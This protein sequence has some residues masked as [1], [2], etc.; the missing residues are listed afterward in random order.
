MQEF[1]LRVMKSVLYERCQCF[2]STRIHLTCAPWS[3]GAFYAHYLCSSAFI[4]LFGYPL[5]LRMLWLNIFPLFVMILLLQPQR[6]DHPNNLPRCFR[7]CLFPGSVCC[8][9]FAALPLGAASGANLGK[10]PPL[11][12]LH[13]GWSFQSPPCPALGWCSIRRITRP[14]G[15]GARQPAV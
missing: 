6:L 3:W 10:Y 5:A 7:D 11:P 9:F 8:G 13:P 2:T 4:P 1:F 15:A 14:A 12:S